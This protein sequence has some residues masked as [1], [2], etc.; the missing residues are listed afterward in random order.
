MNMKIMLPMLL[1]LTFTASAADNHPFVHDV[2]RK[3]NVQNVAASGIIAAHSVTII[4]E[5]AQVAVIEAGQLKPFDQPAVRLISQT[6][7]LTSAVQKPLLSAQRPPSKAAT[8]PVTRDASTN[9]L[10]IKDVTN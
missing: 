8:N 10:T 5:I 6:T 7:N 1:T 4:A 3:T 9:V 2:V